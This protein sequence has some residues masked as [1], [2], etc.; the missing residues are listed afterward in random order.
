MLKNIFLTA[1]AIALLSAC[2]TNQDY[3][4]SGPMELAPRAKAGF[5]RF[6]KAGISAGYFAITPDGGRTSYGYS[7][8]GAAQCSGNALMVAI[9]SCQRNS[10]GQECRI[11]AEG[12]TVV[13]RFNQP[14]ATN[15]PLAPSRSNQPVSPILR[16]VNFKNIEDD[17]LCR[18]AVHSASGEWD[19]N[20]SRYVDEAKRRNISLNRCRDLSGYKPAGD[21]SAP[22]GQAASIE[23]RL[24]AIKN[25]LDNGLITKDEAEKKRA[26]VL[27]QF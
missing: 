12:E 24:T 23:E 6:K 8:C 17:S 4:G 15:A 9:H 27:K 1:V 14:A 11:Y 2:Q 3:Y 13:W 16:T 10:R 7:F 22:D 26:E 18:I 21:S 5:E 25:L 20:V 19:Q